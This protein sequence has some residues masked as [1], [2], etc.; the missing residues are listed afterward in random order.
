MRLCRG[1]AG[2]VPA[3][4]TPIYVP[5]HQRLSVTF[6]RLDWRARR[7]G[8]RLRLPLL[9]WL[10]HVRM[11]A[12]GL[13]STCGAGVARSHGRFEGSRARGAISGGSTGGWGST[14]DYWRGSWRGLGST[15][16]RSGRNP[17]PPEFS[18]GS[19]RNSP[20]L[21]PWRQVIHEWISSSYHGW[22]CDR[23]GRT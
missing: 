19:F 11:G 10:C 18:R 6:V 1:I 9:H 17:F 15:A 7:C 20:A 12:V 8:S 14:S 21:D 22:R 23:A 2:D 5:G 3:G 13:V 4:G 16:W